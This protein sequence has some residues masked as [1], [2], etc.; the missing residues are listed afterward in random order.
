[1]KKSICNPAALA[2]AF[3]LS[4]ATAHA[5]TCTELAAAGLTDASLK[6]YDAAVLMEVIEHVD[7]PRLPALADAVFGHAHPATVIVTTPNVEYNA[8]YAGLTGMRHHDH[9]FEWDRAT[10]ARWAAQVADDFGYTVAI[11]GIGAQ[12]ETLGAPTQLAVFSAGAA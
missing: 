9:R 8:N 10:F 1:M 3:G 4:L 5:E 7:E 6:G 12:D 11:G 2:I